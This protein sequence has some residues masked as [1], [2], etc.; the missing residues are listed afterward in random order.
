MSG[1]DI[2]ETGYQQHP[3]TSH[4]SQKPRTNRHLSIP[5][6][7]TELCTYLLSCG[8]LPSEQD[9]LNTNLSRLDN[10]LGPLPDHLHTLKTPNP[11]A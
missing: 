2:Q 8:W 6:S 4:F 11:T 1:H 9:K 3:L 7:L 5:T 10:L